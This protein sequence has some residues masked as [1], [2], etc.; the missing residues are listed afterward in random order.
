MW[1]NIGCNSS[2]KIPEIPGTPRSKRNL[3][4]QADALKC[5]L[6]WHLAR[7]EA[8]TD[9]QVATILLCRVL[10]LCSLK[11]DIKSCHMQGVGVGG[12]LIQQEFISALPMSSSPGSWE[13]LLIFK[14]N[15]S[16]HKMHFL[17]KRFRRPGSSSPIR[18]VE[19]AKKKGLCEAP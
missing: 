19:R 14:L 3:W 1:R 7:W 9:F 10:H 18:A 4:D 12:Q 16:K 17:R 6:G 8:N 5:L 13:H 11:R 15:L 2:A